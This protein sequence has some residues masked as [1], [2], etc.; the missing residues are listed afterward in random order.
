MF[1]V[2]ILPV[3]WRWAM[4]LILAH[5]IVVGDIIDGPDD[6]SKVAEISDGGHGDLNINFTYKNHCWT[7]VM[8]GEKGHPHPSIRTMSFFFSTRHEALFLFS[9]FLVSFIGSERSEN[10]HEFSVHLFFKSF[11]EYF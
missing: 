1:N 6:A 11:Y 10:I 8:K 5:E 9:F 4:E 3:H 2:I 7:G